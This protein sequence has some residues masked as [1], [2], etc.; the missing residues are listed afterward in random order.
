VTLV[1]FVLYFILYQICDD[2]KRVNIMKK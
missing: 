1:I 2:L